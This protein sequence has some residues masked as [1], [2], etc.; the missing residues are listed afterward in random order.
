MTN[1]AGVCCLLKT[2]CR[3]SSKVCATAGDSAWSQD[4]VKDGA[5][6]TWP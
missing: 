2:F 4:C 5:F 6:C 3:F 1:C